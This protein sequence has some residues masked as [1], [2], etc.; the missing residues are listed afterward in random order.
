MTNQGSSKFMSMSGLVPSTIFD[1]MNADM[2]VSEEME[3]IRELLYEMIKKN[4]PMGVAST[5]LADKYHEEF[6]S[7]GLGRELPSDWLQQVTAAEEFEAQ[8]RG[9][10][11]IL[12]VRLSNT[13]SFKRPPINSV[14]VRVVRADVEPT[15]EELKEI[16]LR[17]ETEPLEHAKSFEKVSSALKC[18]AEVSVVAFDSHSRMFIRATVDDD[19]FNSISSTLEE[20][21]D[22]EIASPLDSRVQIY[23]ILAGGAYALRDSNGTWFRVIAQDPPRNGQVR[24]FFVDVGVEENYPVNALRL[25]PPPKHPV[26]SVGALV[27]EV[28]LDIEE[29]DKK[30]KAFSK[31][32]LT[33][34]L[35]HKQT[36]SSNV[37]SLLPKN[38]KLV[39]MEEKNGR[40]HV[41]M[42]DENQR[43]LVAE[44]SQSDATPSLGSVS[45]VSQPAAA[46]SL[47]S[48]W[49][50]DKPFMIEPM[51]TSQ[52]PKTVFPASALFAAGPMDIS[53][54]QLSLDPMPDY[55]YTKL[56]EECVLPE[57]E[58]SGQPQLGSFYA[59][60]IDD[61]WERVQCLR[62][63]KIDK[64]AYC[65]YLVD[66][67]AFHYVRKEAM[68]KLN[69]AS[70]FKK[71]LMFKCKVS[72]VRPVGGKEFWSR[73]SHEAVREFFEAAC[74]EAV[75]VDLNSKGW[76]S[77]KQLNAP[78][79]PLCEARISCCGRDLGDWLVACGLAL[80]SDG[81]I[82]D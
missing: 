50:F 54:R 56:K 62:P 46:T 73:E 14:N 35:F 12:F 72:G 68:R 41:D 21:F 57:S 40:C 78:S 31:E 76:S 2:D 16:K 23:E 51:S 13:S 22:Q 48:N 34:A 28:C 4:F 63:S 24:C 82:F 74:G 64:M 47:P 36:R 25:L 15:P 58:I 32:N 77:W 37:P 20:I 30:K 52:M 1:K 27:K 29:S 19:T 38:F 44:L 17:K 80:P 75:M 9:P 3:E 33:E 11:T 67:G 60:S 79:V 7:K 69:S 18:G 81:D 65:V 10:I 39:T 45:C 61:R 26:V 5:H 42:G 8:T 66:V 6:V 49:C 43:S 59:A 71:M 70:P 55:M 53:L